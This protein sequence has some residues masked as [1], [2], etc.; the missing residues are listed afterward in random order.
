MNLDEI[1][2]ARRRIA[3]ALVSTSAHS[4]LPEDEQ[5]SLLAQACAEA[6]DV[7]SGWLES[8]SWA[9]LSPAEAFGRRTIADSVADLERLRPF[10]PS[11]GEAI[12]RIAARQG[13]V[14]GEPEAED[15]ATYVD[16]LIRSVTYTARR[17]RRLD[18]HGLYQDA[19]SKLGALRDSACDTAR[20]FADDAAK[21]ASDQQGKERTEKRKENRRHARSVLKKVVGVLFTVVVALASTTPATA[22]QNIPEW[23]HEV[24]NVLFVHQV[25]HTAAPTV[26]IAPPQA[27]PRL[28]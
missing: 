19:T 12:G 27:G 20:K 17:N 28:G 25:A 14:P 18:G 21:R 2:A 5:D 15:P 1:D 13:N 7:L 9:R 23:G 22:G 10:L 8:T 11:V 26:S 16:K 6:C 24:V 3:D 4:M